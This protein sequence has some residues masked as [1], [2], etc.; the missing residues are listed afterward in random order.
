MDEDEAWAFADDGDMWGA[1]AFGA[2][3]R[4]CVTCKETGRDAAQGTDTLSAVDDDGLVDECVFEVGDGLI[5][6]EFGDEDDERYARL[7]A[8]MDRITAPGL[9]GRELGA[10]GEMTAQAWL[11]SRHMRVIAANWRTRYGEL[12]IIAL[13]PHRTI[14][15]VEVKTRRTKRFGA[16]EEA[17]HPGKQAN[18]RRAA[19]QWL[20]ACGKTVPHIGI[21]FDV[22]AV[23]VHCDEVHMHHIPEA[24]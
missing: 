15:F 7:R 14:L 22:M 23:Q 6:D 2:L 18:L 21:R 10:I 1:P 16:P 20:N 11:E 17:V 3:P 5:G 19:V 9:T 13:T 12:D 4:T 24:F 8:C